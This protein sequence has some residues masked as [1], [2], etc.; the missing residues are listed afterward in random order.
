[1][2]GGWGSPG[3]R[4]FVLSGTL[5]KQGKS[6]LTQGE[7]EEKTEI[8]CR[9]GQKVLSLQAFYRQAA[10]V[11]GKRNRRRAEKDTPRTNAEQA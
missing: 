10:S 2:A 3:R 5:P 4:G 7:K 8:I 6:G 1:L 9:Y 11:T